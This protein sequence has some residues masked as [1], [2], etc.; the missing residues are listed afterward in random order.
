[1]QLILIPTRKTNF[2]FIMQPEGENRIG[3]PTERR[4]W[5]IVQGLDPNATLERGAKDVTTEQTQFS[6]YT[7]PNL[8]SPTLLPPPPKK[9]AYFKHYGFEPEY[10]ITLKL[11][12]KNIWSFCIYYI[13]WNKI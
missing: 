11:A 12:T 4:V 3:M 7:P 9:K 2:V 5:R 10:K 8:Y 1:M 6:Y 13:I